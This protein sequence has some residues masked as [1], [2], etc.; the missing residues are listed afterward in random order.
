MLGRRTGRACLPLIGIVLL[1][2]AACRRGGAEL[3][4][5]RAVTPG[6]ELRGEKQPGP[7]GQTVLGLLYTVATGQDY[8][9]ER[10]MPA[11]VGT[12]SRRYSI[13]LR[14]GPDGR[15]SGRPTLRVL[16]KSTRVLHL[17]VVLV[18]RQGLEHESARTLLSGDWHELNFDVFDPPLEDW[19]QV[20]LLRVVDR[21]G[22][23]GGLGPV[24]LKLAGLPLEAP[25]R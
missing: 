13:P 1:A 3:Y 11:N 21:T 25:S 15:W 10:P 22:G 7:E 18:D 5:W 16:G 14:R 20:D 2:Q 19:H 24:S 9:I 12:P 6:V 23:L 17:A 4:G 8:A